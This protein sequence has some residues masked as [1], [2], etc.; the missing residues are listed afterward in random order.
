MHP[1]PRG[2]SATR[3]QWRGA[4]EAYPTRCGSGRGG[5]SLLASEAGPLRPDGCAA[6][7]ASG[8]DPPRS[9]GCLVVLAPGAGPL[10]L[11]GCT[12]CL[13]VW[14]GCIISYILPFF[15]LLFIFINLYMKL[16]PLVYLLI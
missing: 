14:S 16:G 2:G 12:G 4:P 15:K 7:L 8:E 6:A 10:R 11:E 13:G 5:G 3:R 9:S 1:F